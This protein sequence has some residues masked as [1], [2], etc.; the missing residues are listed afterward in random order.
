ML[1]APRVP[2]P[3]P[4]SVLQAASAAT[5]LAAGLTPQPP[6][7]AALPSSPA[8]RQREAAGP[9]VPPR[10]QAPPNGLLPGAP[11]APSMPLWPTGAHGLPQAGNYD[12]GATAEHV[13][14]DAPQPNA[15]ELEALAPIIWK[16]M[17]ESVN[18]RLDRFFADEEV[19]AMV[20]RE[21]AAMGRLR[22]MVRKQQDAPLGEATGQHFKVQ[23]P[24]PYPG[25]QY[26]KSKCLEDRY[27]RYARHGAVVTGHVEDE[28]EWLRISGQV[29]LPMRVGT[30]PI[31]VP[32]SAVEP[33]NAVTTEEA[34]LRESLRRSL[35]E[36]ICRNPLSNMDEAN[37]HLSASVN[38]F[39]N[40][41]T[42]RATSPRGSDSPRRSR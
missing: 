28:G 18:E 35:P 37:R 14:G 4:P 25:V 7:T 8:S 41:P 31:L 6:A 30:I 12:S 36:A 33:V 9:A 16:Q 23:V 21:I 32:V 17:D 3:P 2:E 15:A 11:Q 39:S 34:A 24:K 19:W 42:P 10:S 29:Y 1:G 13:F 40:G 26:R 38:P 27:P 22:A 20:E 5:D